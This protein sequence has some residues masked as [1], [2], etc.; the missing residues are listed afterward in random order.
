M[1]LRKLRNV[2][3]LVIVCLMLLTFAG[4]NYV[5]RPDGAKNNSTDNSSRL[6]SLLEPNKPDKAP[7]DDGEDEVEPPVDNGA[8]EDGYNEGLDEGYTQGYDEGLNEGYTQ[9]YDEGLAENEGAYDEGYEAGK[10]DGYDE[11][12]ET[13]KNEAAEDED[14]EEEP[15]IQS[16]FIA[17]GDVIT[18]IDEILGELT[19]E[20][21]DAN[22][23]T[24]V[25]DELMTSRTVTVYMPEQ[26]FE[27]QEEAIGTVAANLNM[28]IDVRILT[29]DYASTLRREVLAGNKADLMYVDQQTWGYSHHYTQDI[30]KFINFEIADKL[31]TFSSEL[32]AKFAVGSADATKKY[33][34]SGISAPYLLVYNKN[35]IAIPTTALEGDT[36]SD[37]NAEA[38][39]GAEAIEYKT[40]ELKDP[41]T[42]YSEGTWGVQAFA[43]ILKAS[44]TAGRVGY[45]SFLNDDRNLDIWFG[46][47]N[48]AGFSIDATIR[49]TLVE[50]G[51]IGN[52]ALD[53]VGAHMDYLQT[54]YWE[55]TGV[56]NSNYIANFVDCGYGTDSFDDAEWYK[57]LDK[58]LGVYS[59]AD[60]VSAYSFMPIDISEY[61]KVA[62][63]AK[64]KGVEID[65]VPAPY[66]YLVEQAV[67]MGDPDEEG[68]YYNV[69]NYACEQYAASMIGGFSVLKTCEN[70]SVALRVAEE[71][72]KVWKSEYEASVKALMTEDQQARY[73]SMKDKPGVSFFRS[74]VS[75]V[76]SKYHVTNGSDVLE[77]L[78]K[79]LKVSYQG[80]QSF[81]TTPGT[82]EQPMYAKNTT[83]GSY[84]PQ[85]FKKWSEFFYGKVSD[86]DET[87]ALS[88]S[89]LP[90]L[91]A[92][93]L[94]ASMLFNE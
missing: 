6:Q 38:A 24:G 83:L 90:S 92:A 33:V 22:S 35:N 21:L 1:K 75:N 25:K 67:R 11:G 31:G 66:G 63:Y 46:M 32:S 41:A 7:V 87:T 79:D 30:S 4:C 54:L 71:I 34:A 10:T 76:E 28:N 74:I 53:S 84:V 85:T 64:S 89:I 40:V 39:A 55:Q 73:D 15:E 3:A 59:G 57:T 36:Y 60:L 17:P 19:Q 5:D 23:S 88:S 61:E 56:D 29:D 80:L 70:P 45:V 65:F 62:E 9:G 72:T 13:G 43:E 77:R 50:S 12:Y 86:L 91:S 68:Y 49:N 69:D 52:E 48:N 51:L 78:N 42:M 16:P 82:L 8:Y 14:E 2:I 94:P 37:P 44:T 27:G 81:A 18:K 47:E 93:Y 58:T 26:L 20:T